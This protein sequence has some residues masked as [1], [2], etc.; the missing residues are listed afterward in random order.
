MIHT[1][2]CPSCAAP[3]EFED[4][5]DRATRRCPFCGN[6]VVVPDSMRRPQ[7][8]VSSFSFDARPRVRVRPAAVIVPIVIIVLVFVGVA[9]MSVYMGL[10]SATTGA[11]GRPTFTVN[12]PTPPPGLVGDAKNAK[13]SAANVLLKFGSEGT[14]PGYFKDARS[15][16]VDGE[17]RIYVGE[18][19][20]GRIQVFDPSGKFITQWT[21]DPE[22]PLRSMAVDRRGTV[23]VAQ[24]GE[25]RKFEGLTGEPLGKVPFKD[26]GFDDVVA[27]PDGGL[28]AAWVR[29]SSDDIVRFDASGRVT[30]QLTKAI[31]SQSRR[32]ELDVRLAADGAG[33]IYAL[34]TFNDAVFKFSPDG[35]YVTRFGGDG[36]QPGQFRAPSSV[37]ADNRGRVY[38]TDFKGVQ[39]FDENGR[40]IDTFDVEGAASGMAFNDQNELFVVARTQVFK[41]A[42]K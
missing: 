10:R 3:F 12:I 6:T 24:R 13:S 5:Q 21:A 7:V 22:L 30:L 23:Y 28:L 15:I 19:T 4:E 16:A 27:L 11:D 25:L 40:Y 41:F 42:V 8:H 18:Y 32:S 29:A 37:A 39:V 17:G 33:N 2:K 35:R 20:G 31:S 36:D 38:V 9:G 34:G 26:N 14:G 1:L